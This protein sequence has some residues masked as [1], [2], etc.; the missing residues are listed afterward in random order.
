MAIKIYNYNDTDFS[1]NG[2][3]VIQPRKAVIHKELGLSAFYLDLEIDNK[4]KNFLEEGAIVSAPLRSGEELF[5]VTDYTVK[6]NVT[7]VKCN[8]LFFD[9]TNSVINTLT[10]GLDTGL[11]ALN[12]VKNASNPTL[13]FTFVSDATEA[14]LFRKT[15][16][17]TDSLTAIRDI[18][19]N[20][21]SV[22]NVVGKTIYMNTNYSSESEVTIQ[23]AKN[24][25]DISV[26]YDW[27]TI[28]TKVMPVGRDG[29]K[30]PEVYVNSNYQQDYNRIYTRVVQ[31][32]QEE[33]QISQTENWEAVRELLLRDDLR[34][35]AVQWIRTVDR[36]NVNYTVSSLIQDNIDVGDIIKV[37][38]RNINLDIDTQ[39]I[40]FEYDCLTGL[41]I[42]VEFGNF[43]KKRLS[44]LRSNIQTAAVNQAI[45]QTSATNDLAYTLQNLLTMYNVKFNGNSIDIF[46]NDTVSQA[47]NIIRLDKDGISHADGL[48]QN[49]NNLISI[50]AKLNANN[51]KIE[52]YRQ[53][54]ARSGSTVNTVGTFFEVSG[55]TVTITDDATIL[56]S[57]TASYNG[58][59]VK[60][61]IDVTKNDTLTINDNTFIER[62]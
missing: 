10:L 27:S 31:F 60:G 28:C 51:L 42:K 1:H 38:D 48:N 61:L 9:C 58:Q 32:Q 23:Y 18:A 54:V 4:Y 46:D 19:Q 41:Y 56:I 59:I 20:Y 55:N 2:N 62:T 45:N 25:K 17:N 29:I 11:Q 16:S 37:S 7:T 8:H 26:E 39:V 21:S 22:L 49:F 33:P 36:P 3:I 13:D 30:L 15:Y 34:M 52:N 35:Q 50:D 14:Q 12:K 24:L 44:D 57:G 40:S 6:R 43:S 5:R 53:I 47:Q